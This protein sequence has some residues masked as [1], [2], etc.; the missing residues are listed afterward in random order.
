MND[1]EKT[2]F[3]KLPIMWLVLGLPLASI[4]AGVSLVVIAARSGG[5]DVVRDDVRRV[6]QIQTADLGPD[7]RAQ[8]LG[9]S[10]IVRVAEGRVEVIP[11]TGKFPRNAPLQLTLQHPARAAEDVLIELPSAGSGWS[12]QV[13]IDDSHD[14]SLQLAATDG[15]WRLRGR[16]PRQQQ[17]A[18]VAPS[19][20]P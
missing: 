1:S 8:E 18:R 9:L 15:S 5:A 4:V 16:L 13:D 3:W 17:A 7:A 20:Q 10:A 11:A 2:P 14:W 6:S 12:A 19:L